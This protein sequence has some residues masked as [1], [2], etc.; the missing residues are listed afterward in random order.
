M[1]PIHVNT[2][3]RHSP[4]RFPP[5]YSPPD[6]HLRSSTRPRSSAPREAR[7]RVAVSS[8]P[9]R[10]DD[11][12]CKRRPRSF[13]QR[14]RN[15]HRRFRGRPFHGRSIRRMQMVRLGPRLWRA[16]TCNPSHDALSLYAVSQVGTIFS[17]AA[18]LRR[19]SVA[20]WPTASPADC[21]ICAPPAPD[22][23]GGCREYSVRKG[24]A[25]ATRPGQ[26]VSPNQA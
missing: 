14:A 20:P 21:R 5:A 15:R 10:R 7:R 22:A 25:F 19:I 13:R 4:A 23:K 3:P 9:L 16:I 1:D 17:S 6:D 24:H 18:L 11:F 12:C 2:V 8:R 26:I